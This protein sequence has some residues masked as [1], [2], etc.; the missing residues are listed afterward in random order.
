MSASPD[1][2]VTV[3]RVR[4]DEWRA[5]RELRRESTSDPDAAIAFLE[6]P[7]QV[8][9]RPDAFWIERAALA[10][11][12]ETAAQFVAVVDDSWVGS[13]SVLIRATGQTDHLGRFVDD[14]R[15][16]VVGVYV[17]PAYRGSGAVD[18]LLAAAADWA[19]GLGLTLLHLDVHRDNL[20]AQGAYRRAGFE[21]TGETYT[22]AIGP[23]LVMS[24]PLP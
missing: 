10:S 4:A 7:A 1:P 19:A 3:R 9:A 18:L 20:R 8:E 22:S 14:R 2:R 21:P 11:E 15:A 12:S 13:L 6:T 23:E 24:R 17:N 5:V 16:D